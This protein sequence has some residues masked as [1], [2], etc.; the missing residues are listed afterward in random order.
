MPPP[1][2]SSGQIQTAVVIPA[3]YPDGLVVDWH[4]HDYHQLVYACSGVMMVEASN[5]LWVIPPQRAVWVPAGVS[6]KVS[7]HGDAKMRNLYVNTS[8]EYYLPTDS[9]VFNISPLMRELI[10]HLASAPDLHLARDETGRLIQVTLDQLKQASKVSFHLPVALNTKL[11]EVCDKILQTPDDNRT[12]S[13]WA[14]Y[15][16]ISSRSLSRLFRADLGISFVEYR[17]QV[18]MLEALKQLASSASVT[19]VALEVGFSSLS[20]FNRIFKRYFGTTPGH[21]FD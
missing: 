5:N 20:A 8:Y 4:Q 9:C 13:E 12:L 16:N 10:S 18:R 11:K 3:N 15:L 7:M 1:L 17:Q 19:R 21:F 6:H 2:F 14:C